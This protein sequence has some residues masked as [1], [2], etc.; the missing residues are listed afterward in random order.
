MARLYTSEPRDTRTIHNT[1]TRHVR[2]LTCSAMRQGRRGHC[3]A[4]S[5]R[6]SG[7]GGCSGTS[8]HCEPLPRTSSGDLQPSRYQHQRSRFW[9]RKPVHVSLGRFW[10]LTSASTRRSCTHTAQNHSI[11]GC[12]SGATHLHISSLPQEQL[13]SSDLSENSS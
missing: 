5:L 6:A 2:R 9:L 8:A 11:R 10:L 7:L 13:G 12:G 4:W 3:K 1:G